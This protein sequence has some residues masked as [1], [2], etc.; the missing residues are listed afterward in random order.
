MLWR[1]R[2]HLLPHMLPRRLTAIIL[3]IRG[4]PAIGIRSEAVTL[5][6]AA[7]GLARPMRAL[8][9]WGLAT[10]AADIIAATGTDAKPLGLV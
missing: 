1:L 3:V 9:G 4:L 8:I 10:M 2:P 5:G 6:M 7:I